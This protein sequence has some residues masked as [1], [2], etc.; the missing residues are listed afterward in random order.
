MYIM[1]NEYCGYIVTINTAVGWMPPIYSCP[2]PITLK[3]KNVLKVG[4]SGV[5]FKTC[6]FTLCTIGGSCNL[7]IP[8][9]YLH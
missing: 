3:Q 2:Q 8:L 4:G 9:N 6:F 7:A 5:A 1:S